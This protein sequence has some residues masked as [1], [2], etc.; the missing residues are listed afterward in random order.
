MIKSE[1]RNPKYEINSKFSAGHLAVELSKAQ[2]RSGVT[3]I[4]LMVAMSIIMIP[5]LAVGVLLTRNNRTWK[6]IFNDANKR[7]NTDALVVMTKFSDIGR[8]SNR[9]EYH[10]YKQIG[11]NFIEAEPAGT[12]QEV[13]GGEA[14]EFRL[15]LNGDNYSLAE[16]RIMDGYALFYLDGDKLKVDY[17]NPPAI[18]G[19]NRNNPYKTE[20]LAE[21]V[22]VDSEIGAFQHTANSPTGTTQGSIRTNIILTDPADHNDIEIMK[23]NG[24]YIKIMTG[25]FMREEYE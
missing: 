7:I 2:N 10:I 18:S 5:L 20:T 6:D 19:G 17:G 21:N 23:A 8:C 4:E 16:P 14:V 12:E 9:S 3:L 22:T 11:N 13:V 15:M 1:T 25:V 24:S